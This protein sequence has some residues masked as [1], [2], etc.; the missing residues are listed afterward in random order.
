MQRLAPSARWRELGALPA[1]E[2]ET[3]QLKTKLLSSSRG[4]SRC[5]KPPR[6]RQGC[7]H[8]RPQS[9][10]NDCATTEAARALQRPLPRC[11]R[12]K[13]FSLTT[14]HTLSPRLKHTLTHCPLDKASF[15]CQQNERNHDF[16][17][18]LILRRQPLRHNPAFKIQ[19]RIDEK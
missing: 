16:T 19:V 11:H 4:K 12:C 1:P 18:F 3:N 10:C 8:H 14:R 15:P 9:E 2:K 13:L 6:N 17:P 7:A 5:L